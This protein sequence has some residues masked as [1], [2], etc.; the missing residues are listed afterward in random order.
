[1]TTRFRQLHL[2]L[3]D[4]T[5]LRLAAAA[6]RDRRTV[7]DWVRLT[8]TDVIAGRYELRPDGVEAA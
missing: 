8:L 7:S 2:R 5:A 1:M 4:E 6:A 3:D